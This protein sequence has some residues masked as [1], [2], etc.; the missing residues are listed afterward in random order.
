[1]DLFQARWPGKNFLV[2]RDLHEGEVPNFSLVFFPQ[3]C[4]NWKQ[5]LPDFAEK[6][7]KRTP[8]RSGS[9]FFLFLQ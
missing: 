1:V 7:K 3:I 9:I 4:E 2:F 5:N 6:K 8:K